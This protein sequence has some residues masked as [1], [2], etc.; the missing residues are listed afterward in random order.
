MGIDIG[1]VLATLGTVG[2]GNPLSLK[3]SYSIGG[4]S[5]RA[6]NLLGNLFGLLGRSAKLSEGELL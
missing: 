2:V 5:R 3:P 4:V 1:T 6:Q